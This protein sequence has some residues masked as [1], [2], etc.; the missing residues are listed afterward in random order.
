MIPSIYALAAAAIYGAADFLGGTVA[1]RAST[2]AAVVATQGAGLALL[3]V[4]SPLM[5]DAVVTPNDLL[6]GA[7]AGLTGSVGVA[8]L[9]LVPQPHPAGRTS[10]ILDRACGPAALNRAA[11]LTKYQSTATNL[12]SA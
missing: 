10:L 3:L 1:K 4:G 7:L 9:Y 5:L 8:L 11:L 2:L 6:F 12:Q